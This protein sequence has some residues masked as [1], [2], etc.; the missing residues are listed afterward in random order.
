MTDLKAIYLIVSGADAARSVPQLLREL[1]QFIRRSAVSRRRSIFTGG[2][3]CK[4]PCQDVYA[5]NRSEKRSPTASVTVSVYSWP[6]FLCRFW[7]LLR[8]NRVE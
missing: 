7:S 1:A 6:L 4:N 3:W 2:K 8:L 5:G